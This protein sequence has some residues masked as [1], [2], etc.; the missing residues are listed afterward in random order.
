MTEQQQAQP[1][2]PSPV[3]SGGGIDW[4]VWVAGIALIV[5]FFAGMMV[6]QMKWKKTSDQ[7]S[8]ASTS[9]VKK[10]DES[11]DALSAAQAF[12]KNV[13]T[14]NADVF[15]AAAGGMTPQ[16]QQAVRKL[17]KAAKVKMPPELAKLAK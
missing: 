3:P 17:A 10:L 14:Q 15:N 12:I 7:L 8:K 6:S 16:D 9:V 2:A 11:Y 4:K 13:K 1:S 5:G